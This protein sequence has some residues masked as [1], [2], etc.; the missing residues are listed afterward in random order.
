MGE[1]L[2]RNKTIVTVVVILI[3]LFL[4][5]SLLGH[6]KKTQDTAATKQNTPVDNADGDNTAESLNSL[7][8]NIHRVITSNDDL[9]AQNE[10]LK[11]H[12]DYLLSH[13]KQN[14]TDNLNAAL[15]ERGQD[16]KAKI[17]ALEA[18]L[19][20]LNTTIELEKQN[21]T[22]GSYSVD[23]K[24]TV[25]LKGRSIITVEGQQLVAAP[26][27]SN[28]VNANAGTQNNGGITGNNTSDSVLHP[29]GE[30]GSGAAA[31]K[32]PAPIPFYTIN[33]GATLA[34]SVTM[35]T[36]IGR[37]PVNGVVKTPYPFKM[38]IGADNMAANGHHIPGISGAIVQGTTV[39]DMAL[40]CVKG[41]IT[42]ITFVFQ[43][44][45][46]YTQKTQ[47]SGNSAD[48]GF[49][50]GLGYISQPNGNP[51]FPG[52]FKTNAKEYLTTMGILGGIN[53]GGQAY[54]QAQQTAMSNANGG[55]TTSLTG[56]VGKSVLGGVAAGSTQQVMNW[57]TERE[58]NSFDAVVVP[59]GK[60]AVINITK[61]IDIDYK[62]DGRKI[63]YEHTTQGHHN[64]S[65][66]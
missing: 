39:G 30:N 40:R 35:S 32:K 10:K 34:G 16:N 8:Q 48:L 60:K 5:V 7:T 2:K 53:L 24:H 3:V 42:T 57:Y 29:S 4:F 64:T 11:K 1:F 13:I 19:K 49:S 23:G 63:Y 25:N 55:V 65:L 15:K 27:V 6:H 18:Q 26:V 44:G 20:T 14:V 31:N 21:G 36:L 12:Y 43:D 33:N 51:C 52:V 41:Y 47:T 50:N 37:V 62:K 17:T 58:K 46:I 61:E 66:D 9:K 45:T 22:G 38:I 59:A 54:Q 28:A 56:S